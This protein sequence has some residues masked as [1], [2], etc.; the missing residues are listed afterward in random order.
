MVMVSR[1]VG[2]SVRRSVGPWESMT[3]SGNA[4]D[5]HNGGVVRLPSRDLTE[6]R[7]ITA[8]E[9]FTMKTTR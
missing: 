8:L 5:T 1:S 2:P 3:Q 4:R 6:M 7:I 9:T